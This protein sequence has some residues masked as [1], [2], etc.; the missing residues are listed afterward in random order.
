M[1]ISHL[2]IKNYRTFKNFSINLKPLTLI[3]RE[4]NIGKSNLLDSIGLIL[5][6][7]VSFFKRRI[8]ETADFNH[9]VILDF[10]RKIL[11]FSIPI[12]EIEFP[13]INIEIILK[14]WDEDQETV[15]SEWFNNPDFTEAVLSYNF[16][17]TSKF[18]KIDDL[19]HQ[20][21]FIS[22]FIHQNT[23]EVYENLPEN[24]KLDLI[25]FPISKYSYTI[26]GGPANSQAN[27]YHL[28]QLKFELLDALRDACS[29][30]VASHNNKLLFRILNSKEEKEYQDLK[31]QLVGLQQAI[32]ENQALQDIKKGISVQLDKISL[33]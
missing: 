21:N 32:D 8:L 2:K 19:Q 26:T 30:L 27:S 33:V 17:P 13:E 22:A 3:I 9:E 16:S 1:Y 20:R 4:N 18:N 5:G 24:V 11:D 7:D 14:D 12:S 23:A 15:I 28:N 6:Q 10:K 25:N 29:E 31:G